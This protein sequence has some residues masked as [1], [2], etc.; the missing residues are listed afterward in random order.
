MS[1]CIVV[2]L[3]IGVSLYCTLLLRNNRMLHIN[4]ACI[5][6]N[7]R[8]T[9]VGHTSPR[10]HWRERHDLIASYLQKFSHP[11]LQ[12]LARRWFGANRGPLAHMSDFAGLPPSLGNV[13]TCHVVTVQTLTIEDDIATAPRSH[14]VSDRVLSTGVSRI[15]L[16][17][18]DPA[19]FGCLSD[20][21]LNERMLPSTT[22]APQPRQV[23]YMDF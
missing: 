8:P 18:R 2:V 10:Y 5:Y 6:R 21:L 15:D 7:S 23:L 13:D 4:N 14:L 11:T 20:T 1:A 3:Y 16:N 9:F 17:N 12:F 19:Q 22:L